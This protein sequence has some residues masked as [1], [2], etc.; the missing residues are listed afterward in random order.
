MVGLHI[1]SSPLST[2]R[3]PIPVKRAGRKQRGLHCSWWSVLAEE[4]GFL[5][6]SSVT[7]SLCV[8]RKFPLSLGLSFPICTMGFIQS[9]GSHLMIALTDESLNQKTFVYVGAA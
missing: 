8:L 4:P 3:P 5:Y 7:N 9:V 1:A 2:T 6:P